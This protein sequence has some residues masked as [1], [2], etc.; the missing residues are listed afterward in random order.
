MMVLLLA[1]LA[2][3]PSD[4]VLQGIQRQIDRSES[5]LK[6]EVY[7]FVATTLSR[8]LDPQGRA[9]SIDT[10]ITWKL[11]RGYETLTDSVIYTT[12]KVSGQS[13]KMSREM[14]KLGDTNYVYEM[15]DSQVI[16]FR[17][18]R[19]G[20]GDLSYRL[21]FDPGTWLPRWVEIEMPK[22]KLPLK[23]FRMRIEWIIWED[24]LVPEKMWLLAS[25][26]MLVVSGRMEV[27]TRYSDYR[28]RR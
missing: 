21:G 15:L 24:M 9:K 20:R 4:S 14:P 19:L 13:K 23:E 16:S 5:R 8:E 17:P 22:P 2:L 18:K 27:E 11:R 3:A 10:T 12:T 6:A 26:K 28:L 25:W 1:A 7:S